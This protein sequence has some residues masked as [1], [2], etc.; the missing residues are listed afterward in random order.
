[1]SATPATAVSAPAQVPGCLPA[2]YDMDSLLTVEQFARWRQVSPYTARTALPYTK[3]VIRRSRE[4]V[5]IHPRSYVELS[6]K[7]K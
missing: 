6:V 2:G 4:D 3:G 5:R 1:M 7:R